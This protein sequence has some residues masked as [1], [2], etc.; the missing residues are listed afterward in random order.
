MVLNLSVGAIIRHWGM[1]VGATGTGVE[2]LGALV[3]DLATYFYVD[4]RLIA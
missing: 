1:V 2:D 4:N 3:Q